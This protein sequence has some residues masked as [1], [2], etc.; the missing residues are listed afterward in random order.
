MSWFSNLLKNLFFLLLILQV[1]PPILQNLQKQYSSLLEPHTK[2][3]LLEIKSTLTDASHYIKVLKQF[4]ENNSIK[5]I[6]LKMDS[7]GGAAGTSKLIFDEIMSYKKDHP[8]KPIITLVE[9]VCA[10]G[11]YYIACASDHIISSPAAIIGSIGASIQVPQLKEFLD[12]FKIKFDVTK[13]GTYKTAG[14]PVTE[15]TPEQKEMFQ[16]LTN[17]T[18]NQFVRDVKSRRPKLANLDEKI[19]AQGRIMT[20]GKAL[21]LGLIDEVGSNYDAIRAIKEKAIFEGEIEWIKPSKP[22]NFWAA[23]TGEGDSM[24][25][26]L[27]KLCK[28]YFSTTL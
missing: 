8:N 28:I 24:A 16:E 21:E 23:L 11:G 9:N 10:S 18:Y 12:Q 6:L 15:L 19:W 3:G 1:A 4:F 20:G 25:E 2:V 27:A 26:S 13:S 22:F 7:P 14:N 5:A 17:D